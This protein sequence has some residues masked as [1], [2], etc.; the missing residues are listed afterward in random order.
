V[1]FDDANRRGKGHFNDEMDEEGQR[2]QREPFAVG[3]AESASALWEIVR[4]L[5]ERED[6]DDPLIQDAVALVTRIEGGAA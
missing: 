5:S 2:G 4:L 1:D 3:I 6:A